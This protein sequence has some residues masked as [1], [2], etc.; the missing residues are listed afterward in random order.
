MPHSI[1][2]TVSVHPD[3]LESPELARLYSYVVK[4]S[5]KGRLELQYAPVGRYL[6]MATS[7]IWRRLR[8]L[9][10]L[11]VLQVTKEG[12]AAVVVL[13][14]PAA[15]AVPAPEAETFPIVS[16]EM[17][18]ANLLHQLVR[19]WSP[20]PA[21]AKPDLQAAAAVMAR[22]LKRHPAEAINKAI[23]QSQAVVSFRG[24]VTT[25]EE[26]ETHIDGILQ[27]TSKE[28]NW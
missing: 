27:S 3:V 13:G 20:T 4:H 22:L 16:D 28:F 23:R 17:V 25:A 6:R 1:K 9:E 15:A 24:K 26:L 8:A 5:Q 19:S 18:L 7:S 14:S 11:G 2:P 21:R 10:K 12:A